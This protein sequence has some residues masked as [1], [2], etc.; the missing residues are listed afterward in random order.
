MLLIPASPAR[1]FAQHTRAYDGPGRPAVRNV[2]HRWPVGVIHSRHP[3]RTQ[4]CGL[5]RGAIFAVQLGKAQPALGPCGLLYGDRDHCGDVLGAT[6]TR[7]IVRRL[8]QPLQNRPDRCITP[9]A[10]RDFIGDISRIQ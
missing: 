4:H 3:R 8:P 9:K 1:Q 2:R 6:A 7:Q 5:R 10:L